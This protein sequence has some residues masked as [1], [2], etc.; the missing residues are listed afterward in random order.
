MIDFLVQNTATATGILVF[1]SNINTRLKAGL[2]G[3]TLR[4]ID[5]VYAVNVDLEDRENIL[6]VECHSVIS[7]VYIEK[8]VAR[9]GFECSEL[10]D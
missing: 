6:R 3:D 8:Q 2:V 7:P 10:E 5:G 1:R 4:K 9:L